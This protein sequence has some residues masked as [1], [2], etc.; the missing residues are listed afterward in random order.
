MG[1]RRALTAAVLTV[2]LGALG[3]VARAGGMPAQDPVVHAPVA[4]GGPT[5]RVA[6][7]GPWTVRVM[8]GGPTRRVHVPYSPNARVVSGPA[9]QVSYQGAVAWYRTRLRRAVRRRL[10]DPL[11]VGQPRGDR[12]RRRAPRR[13]AHRRL[14]AVRGAPAPHGRPPHAARAGR[15]ALARD[16]EGD[17]LAPRLVQ[18][19][20]HRPRGHDPPARRERDR[21]ARDRHPPAAGRV[22]RS[23]TSR[24][25]SATAATR[26]RFSS[27]A[28][29]GRARSRSHRSSS[30]AGARRRCAPSST[31]RTRISGRP[32]TRRCRRSSSPS[33]ASRAGGRR[34]G[35]ARS[36]GRAGAC[37][38][39]ARAIVLR[40][41]SIQED[42]EGRGDALRPDDMDAI[43]RRL[44]AIGANATRSQ[45]PLNPALLERLDAAGIL[46]WQG[47]GPVDAPGRVDGDDTRPAPPGAAPRAPRRRAGPD[48]P[49]RADL[50]PRQRG[51]Q[52]R[53]RRRPGR[54]HRLGGAA[55]AP[56][57]SRAP[58]RGRRLGHAHAGR[59]PG[60]CT[61]TST[62][63]AA[64]TTRAGTTTC[65]RARRPST[66]R[67][68]SGSGA[69]TRR[70]RARCSR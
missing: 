68:P 66:R 5:G 56:P 6:L 46:V 12:L 70:S 8:P 35:S 36:A 25:G 59:P 62:R 22:A 42:A 14:P 47:I 40:G 52:Q 26:G 13:R 44:H 34:S 19:R 49:E 64:R 54:V 1:R 9:G 24:R 18:L 20:R 38:S 3:L 32:A 65:T 58:G 37:C 29:S 10:R 30:A 21:R 63:S 69:C 53:S 67:S 61:A 28:A 16:H 55:R 33:P 15:L 41:A 48:S 17:R 39:T 50:E 23:S 57:R 60:S 51:R 43:V 45:H 2:A 31:S 7:D 11:R 4:A 27:R